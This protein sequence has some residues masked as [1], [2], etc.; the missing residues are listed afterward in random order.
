LTKHAEIGD[1]YVIP[2]K[3]GKSEYQVKIFLLNKILFDG[4]GN[5]PEFA[6]DP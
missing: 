4:Y 2:V 1:R 3:Y 5:V 6:S